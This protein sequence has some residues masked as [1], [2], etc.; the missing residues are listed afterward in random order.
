ME[1]R[2]LSFLFIFFTNKYKVAKISSLM[3][4]A[5]LNISHVYME[6]HEDFKNSFNNWFEN[7]LIEYMPTWIGHGTSMVINLIV[8]V[9][10]IYLINSG[11]V[12][13]IYALFSHIAT[14][15][16]SDIIFKQIGLSLLLFGFHFTLL[17]S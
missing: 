7:G 16:D 3:I 4:F 11:I 6:R 10:I 17:C 2:I 15:E 1:N 8:T 5:E 9:F 14:Q 13:S 12:V